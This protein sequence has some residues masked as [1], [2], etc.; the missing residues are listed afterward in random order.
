VERYVS[1]DAFYNKGHKSGSL[2]GTHFVDPDVAG[3]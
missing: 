3:C 2:I 1:A